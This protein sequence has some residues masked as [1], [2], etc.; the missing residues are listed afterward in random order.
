[1][2]TKIAGLAVAAVGCVCLGSMAAAQPPQ[3]L[4]VQATRVLA[5]KTVSHNRATGAPIVDVS[6]SYGIKVDDLDLASHY[7]PIELEKRI[8]DAAM[9]ACKEIGAKYPNSTPNDDD[10]AASATNKAMVKAHEMEAAAKGA[11]K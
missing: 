11:A 3:E 2:K 10:C 9:A 8:R 5:A 4:T 1:M 7:G 6:L